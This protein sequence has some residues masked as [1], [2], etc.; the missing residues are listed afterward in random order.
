MAREEPMEHVPVFEKL[1][2]E[3]TRLQFSNMNGEVGAQARTWLH[4]LEKA[5]E[6]ARHIELL[7][8]IKRPHW[9]LIPAFVLLVV[10]VVLAA[11]ALPQVQQLLTLSGQPQA[12]TSSPPTS[13]QPSASTTPGTA[14]R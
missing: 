1:G 9:S 4:T 2:E 10:A 14:K 5:R 8:E 3:Q 11:L 12:A 13:V 6:E 7:T